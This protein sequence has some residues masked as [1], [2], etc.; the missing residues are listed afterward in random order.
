M[1]GACS[2]YVVEE[3]CIQVSVGTPEG[4]RP[5]VRP[6]IRWEGNIKM[7]IQEVE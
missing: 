5:A 2:R 1:G 4:K 3:R 7:H 6:R